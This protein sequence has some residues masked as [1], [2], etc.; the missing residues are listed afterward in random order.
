ILTVVDPGVGTSRGAVAIETTAGLVLVGPD[1]GVFTHAIRKFGMK[2]AVKIDP[3]KVN[4]DWKPGTFDG[5]DLFSPAAAMLASEPTR[6]NELGQPVAEKDLVTLPLPEVKVE[7]RSHTVRG[8]YVRTDEPY[9]NVW[10]DIEPEH[11][12]K[13][14]IRIGTQ[15]EV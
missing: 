3:L 15:V 14:G 5:R 2:R 1:N 10:T 7:V 4:P 13:A 11:L 12:Q 9:G 6:F 8:T